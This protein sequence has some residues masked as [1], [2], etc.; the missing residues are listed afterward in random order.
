MKTTRAKP[1]ST[2]TIDHIN[3][4]AFK[5]QINENIVK[6]GTSLN[7]ALINCRSIIN[8]TQE[9]QAETKEND[10]DICVLTET[11]IKSDDNLTH[12]HMCLDGYKALSLPRQDH[13]GSGIAIMFRN[14]LSIKEGNR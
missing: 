1:H 10:L 11:W 4:K 6:L 3:L 2:R 7:C 14:H 12:L 9:L 8:K 13:M 5:Q